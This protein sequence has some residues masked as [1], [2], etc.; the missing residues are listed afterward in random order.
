M[1]FEIAQAIFNLDGKRLASTDVGLDSDLTPTQMKTAM[2]KGILVNQEIDAPADS[3][4]LRVGIRDASSGR[5]GSLEI[6]LPR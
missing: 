1:K 3:E 5:V 6:A 2:Q 4:F